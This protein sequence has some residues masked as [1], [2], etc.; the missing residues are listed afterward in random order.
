MQQTQFPPRIEVVPEHATVTETFG[1]T[2]LSFS[3]GALLGLIG[4]TIAV[5]TIGVHELSDLYIPL[6]C[7]GGLVLFGAWELWRRRRRTT[8][9]FAGNQIGIYRGGQLAEVAYR[10][11]MV[12]YQL[13]I[14]N[15]MR[16]LALFGIVGLGGLMAGITMM[17]PAPAFGLCAL[18]VGVGMTGA[19]ASS[20]YA[21]IAC[22]H[23]YVPRGRGSEHVVFTSRA[24]ERFGIH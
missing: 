15:T 6:G 24:I 1:F 12:I 9:A 23:F 21:R 18:G 14:V 17:V 19:C 13:N 3:A 10:S 22:R 5:I 16:E 11:Q 20:V 2:P 8:L 4:S 7:L